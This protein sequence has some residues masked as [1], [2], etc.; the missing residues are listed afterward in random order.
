MDQELSD[1][2][3][4]KLL[5]TITNNKWPDKEKGGYKE[6]ISRKNMISVEFPFKMSFQ[7]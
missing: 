3:L 7:N 5:L 4:F 6:T 1:Q 2:S